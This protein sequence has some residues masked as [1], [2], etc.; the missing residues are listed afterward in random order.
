MDVRKNVL[1]LTATVPQEYLLV[2]ENT[3]GE[4][5]PMVPS[6]RS[7]N[8]GHPDTGSFDGLSPNA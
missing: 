7:T 2:P 3:Y 8:K 5:I 6:H 1:Q 4:I